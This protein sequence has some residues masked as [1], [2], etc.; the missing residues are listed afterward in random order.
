MFHNSA[1]GENLMK[2]LFILL[3]AVVLVTGFAFAQESGDGSASDIEK[4][5][6]EVNIGFPVHWTNGL[7]GNDEDKK[8]TANT[9]IGLG[10]TFNF[11][12]IIGVIIEADVFYGAELSGVSSPTSDHLSLAGANV[13][14]GP[15]FYLFNNNTFRI[16]LAA[17]IH[18][19]YFSD[20]LWIPD[21]DSATD[22][23]WINRNETQFGL[24]ISLGFQFHFDNGVYLFSRTSVIF[25]FIRIHSAEGYDAVGTAY[26]SADPCV[27][28]FPIGWNIKPAV[29]IGIRF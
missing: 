18:V 19:Y 3:A 15:L 14:L 5:N 8:V 22:G 28:V 2:R 13:F 27:D 21:L 23:S 29:G 10:I 20:D 26:N 1:K 6:A 7:H 16:P 9:S 11:T 4:F 17:G 24:G 25:D 12:N